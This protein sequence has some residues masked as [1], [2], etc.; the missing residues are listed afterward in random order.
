MFAWRARIDDPA[1]T[2]LGLKV[3]K[4]FKSATAHRSINKSDLTVLHFGMKTF[5]QLSSAN[6]VDQHCTRSDRTTLGGHTIARAA[7]LE[8]NYTLRAK[9]V[10][11]R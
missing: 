4:L 5:D 3:H 7:D 11:Q 6:R 8:T 9:R 2:H 1:F 10:E